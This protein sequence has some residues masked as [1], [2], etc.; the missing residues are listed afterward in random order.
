MRDGRCRRSCHSAAVRRGRAARRGARSCR[1]PTRSRP[2]S[3][4]IRRAAGGPRPRLTASSTGAPLG[5]R[6][7]ST[8]SRAARGR[9]A[10][11]P[12]RRACRRQVAGR[13]PRRRWRSGRERRRDRPRLAA[14]AARR[15]R[16]R[17]SRAC[18]TQGRRRLLRLF[19]TTGASLFGRGA[20]DE[21]ARRRGG[22]LE[23]LG[24]RGADARVLVPARRRRA[25]GHLPAADRA[26]TRR[27]SSELVALAGGRI[28]A[29]R[30]LPA[31]VEAAGSAAASCTSFFP[32][33]VP[34][35]A[36][37]VGLGEAPVQLRTAGR[38][39]CAARRSRPGWRGGRRV[40]PGLGRAGWSR[41]GA[42]ADPLAAALAAR[43]A[44]RA[45]GADAAGGPAPVGD[46]G[47][48]C[49]TRSTSRIRTAW[50]A[51]V[52]IERERDGPRCGA[53]SAARPVRDLRGFVGSPAVRAAAT[54]CRLRLIYGPGGSQTIREGVAG[55]FAATCRQAFDAREPAVAAA[56][57]EA[58]LSIE[59][60]ASG[61]DCRFS[62]RRRSSRRSA[63]IAPVGDE[64]RPDPGACGDG[65]RA[66]RARR[67]R[68]RLPRR[69]GPAGRR[70]AGRDRARGG[71]LRDRAPA[72]DRSRRRRPRRTGLRA[73]L[74]HAR[75]G[76]GCCCS[77]PEVLPAR[78]GL[79]GAL[80]LPARSRRGRCSAARCSTRPEP[81]STPAERPR[82][83][84]PRGVAGDRTCPALRRWRP[85]GSAP[86][87]SG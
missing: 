84:A 82:R 19:L 56:L 66:S 67:R 53:A 28:A 52:R 47:R 38:G 37:L 59:W 54:A 55:A 13:Q 16:R 12:A 36:A 21:F 75:G 58:R 57:A 42:A 87:A 80:A 85:R 9:A 40:D 50:C 34:A 63:L 73:A 83:P 2:S 86:T 78:A 11:P 72:R 44:P 3:S 20:A 23:L 70:G 71:R 25:A 33:A 14:V 27:A 35:G 1:S 7:I 4:T 46:A 24:L 31:A 43:A 29:A 26:S 62:A 39:A 15:R 45:D 81:C 60:P 64:P 76:R 6:S 74:A 69:G 77:G 61:A 48:A 8:S 68:D 22:L 30:R 32:R 17:W 41:R 79:A 18:P 49:S 65:L 5:R 51:A 10:A